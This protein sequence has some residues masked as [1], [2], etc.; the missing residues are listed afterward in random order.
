MSK[1][2]K[3]LYS[4]QCYNEGI[5][6]K[7]TPKMNTGDTCKYFPLLA[8]ICIYAYKIPHTFIGQRSSCK[9]KVSFCLC[10]SRIIRLHSLLEGSSSNS[11]RWLL[12]FC[13]VSLLETE[14]LQLRDQPDPA[15]SAFNPAESLH[16][17]SAESL[18]FAN[19]PSE[20]LDHQRGCGWKMKG[21]E[22][23]WA[24]TEGE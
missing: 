2:G 21:K 23:G 15:S 4:R 6:M 3:T 17:W 1:P 24:R 13:E 11:S 5:W 19:I 9:V 7:N 10:H 14:Q 20:M 8:W 12:H 16:Y 22:L 18:Q